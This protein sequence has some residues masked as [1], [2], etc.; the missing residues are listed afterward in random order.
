MGRMSHWRPRGVA[1][2]VVTFLLLT[3]V[4]VVVDGTRIAWLIAAIVASAT[5]LL[6]AVLLIP[7]TRSRLAEPDGAIR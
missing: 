1:I 2:L 7:D 4:N 5:I 6:L 3:L